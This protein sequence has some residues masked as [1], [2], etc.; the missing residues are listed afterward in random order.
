MA[1]LHSKIEMAPE[2]GER[3]ITTGELYAWLRELIKAGDDGTNVVE[4]RTGPGRWRP[5]R[6]ARAVAWDERGHGVPAAAKQAEQHWEVAPAEQ[7]AL[8]PAG[9]A[10]EPPAEPGTDV[11]LPDHGA[12]TRPVPMLARQEPVG[13]RHAK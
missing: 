4:I 8:P 10:P 3:D 7:P 1:R 6:Q 13:A 11:V 2:D 9:P 5:M 12:E